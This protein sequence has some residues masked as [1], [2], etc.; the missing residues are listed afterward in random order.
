MKTDANNCNTIDT[1]TAFLNVFGICFALL[2]VALHYQVGSWAGVLVSSAG[3][4][5]LFVMNLLDTEP[6]DP[7]YLKMEQLKRKEI[8]RKARAYKGV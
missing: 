7:K 2:C 5:V 6:V 4:A 3:F 1:I 8:D